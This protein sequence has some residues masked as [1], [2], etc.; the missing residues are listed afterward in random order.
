MLDKDELLTKAKELLKEETTT[1]SYTTWIK[2][3]EIGKIYDDKLEL[4]TMN[5]MQTDAIKSRYYELISNTFSPI[6][7]K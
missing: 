7:L 5:S 4:I 3:L 6:E 1:I 2:P